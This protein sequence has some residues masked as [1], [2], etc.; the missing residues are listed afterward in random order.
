ML[1]WVHVSSGFLHYLQNT[2][3]VIIENIP[4]LVIDA[5]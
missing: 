4:K 3:L 2:T 1:Q 5:K